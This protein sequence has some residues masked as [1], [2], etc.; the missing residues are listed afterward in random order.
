MGASLSIRLTPAPIEFGTDGWRGII[1]AEFTFERLAL[2]APIAAQVLQQTYGAETNHSNLIVVG[3][4]RRFLSEEFAEATAI[5]VQRAGFD[6]LLSDTF[7]PT[8]A[9]SWAVKQHQA[10]G[11]LVITA[12]HN[13]GGYSGLKV[14][15]AFGGSVPPSVTQSIQ[16]QLDNPL[17]PAA[18]PGTLT[19]FN[20]WP[21]YCEI[22][23]SK[24]DLGAIQAAI[25]SGRVTVY[26]DAMHG[27]TA[28]GLGQVLNCPVQEL[29]SSRDPLFGGGA[30]EP[31]PKY[32]TELLRTIR[33]RA[34]SGTATGVTVGFVFDGDGD[35]IAA[36]DGQGNFLSSQILIPILIEHLASR[37]GLS[38]EFIKTV[39]GS[40]LMPKVA[41]L[42]KLPVF[43]TPIGYKYIADRMLQTGGV[44]LGGEESGGIGYGT[45]IPERDGLLS[46][47]YVLEAI[48]ASGQDLSDLY[49]SLQ[50]RTH[51]TSAYDRIDLTLSSEATKQALIA[52]LATTPFTEILG[53]PV[54]EM[55]NPDGYK[56]RLTDG[57]WVLIRFSGTEPVLRLYC[58]AATQPQVEALLHWAQQWA[59]SHEP[60]FR[61]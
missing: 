33:E 23:R 32:M 9:I 16:H 44:L 58:E 57:S 46:A 13:P 18:K 51:F 49:Q 28:T 31:L 40:D 54:Q 30:P 6:V 14:K 27:A 15:G 38:G 5:A 34:A 42:F 21:D 35:R 19:S 29:R 50:Q 53:I 25:T 47:L 41:Q 60:A 39:S 59:L 20:P 12:S 2:V 4:D 43:E 52:E 10:L 17:P 48:T 26:V 3:Y 8:P 61:P 1:A 22:L 55:T 56:I 11:G 36:V 37:R 24:V 45:H 7:V